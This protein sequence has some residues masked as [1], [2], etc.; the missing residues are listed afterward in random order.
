MIRRLAAPILALS[1]MMACTP[2]QLERAQDYQ[3]VIAALCKEAVEL[4]PSIYVTAGCLGEAAIAKLALNPT[5][6]EWLRGMIA[7][8]AAS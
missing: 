3:D 8:R 1:L 7:R 6:A 4:V 5:S 2:A